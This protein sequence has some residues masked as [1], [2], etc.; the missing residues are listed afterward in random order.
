[1]INPQQ[2]DL[3]GDGVGDACD[4]DDDGDGVADAYDN[5]PVESNPGQDDADGDGHGDVCDAFPGDPSEFLDSDGDGMGDDYETRYGL[6]P[7]DP[8]DAAADGDGDGRTNLEEFVQGT[9]PLVNEG[10]VMVPI[11]TILLE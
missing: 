3:D 11:I 4:D 10:A 7:H 6:A 8:T 1:M 9:N 2:S 5:C